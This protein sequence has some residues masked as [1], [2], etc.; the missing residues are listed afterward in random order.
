MTSKSYSTMKRA[1]RVGQDLGFKTGP[2]KCRHM[3]PPGKP[4]GGRRT[5]SPYSEQLRM[6]QMIRFYY[7]V[8]EKQFRNY[9]KNAERKQGS[10]GHNLL[11]SLESRLDN[12]VYRLGFAVTRRE[13]RQLVSH[14]HITVNGKRVNIASYRVLP[15]DIIS[16]ADK[17]KKHLRILAALQLVQQRPEIDWLEL[18]IE[19]MSG[20][21]KSLPKSSDFPPEF[22]VNLVVELYSKC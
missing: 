11:V 2:S 15:G 21:F 8:L 18:D 19:A 1:R 7:G 6:K 12:I 3:G 5:R 9:Y 10:T 13:A 14:G 20:T 17:S 16:V 4:E 22:M